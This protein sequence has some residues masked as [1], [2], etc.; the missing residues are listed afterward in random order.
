MFLGIY[1]LESTGRMRESETVG[2]GK[3]R[4]RSELT[5]GC[6]LFHSCSCLFLSLTNSLTKSSFL[7]TPVSSSR[8]ISE[9]IADSRLVAN[10]NLNPHQTHAFPRCVL[11]ERLAAASSQG[12]A[13]ISSS[14]SVTT[15]VERDGGLEQQ[16]D[17]FLFGF[18][19]RGELTFPSL[20]SFF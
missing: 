6:E 13:N 1:G 16:A 4:E 2:R 20:L 19:L 9:R 18:P 3:R 8:L 15:E 10:A 12:S 17:A 7:Y 11:W 14:P 5:L